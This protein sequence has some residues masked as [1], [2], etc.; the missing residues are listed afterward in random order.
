MQAA[1]KLEAFESYESYQYR[2]TLEKKNEEMQRKVEKMF[3]E[4][5]A[6]KIARFLKMLMLCAFVFASLAV[7]I[8]NYATLYEKQYAVNGLKSEIEQT[9]MDV[10]E[11]KSTLDST[12]SLDNVER[13]AVTELNMQYP[14]P[15][16][17]IYIKS[18]W[19]YA[20][21]KPI[22]NKYLSKEEKS[23]NE[24]LSGHVYDYILKFAFGEKTNLKAI[25]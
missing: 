20:L 21:D 22:Q 12:V 16:Q 1:R 6:K 3:S 19:H 11:I 2:A 23:K 14:K 7:M 25:K 15:E 5:Q 8:F 13:V 4:K 10:E 17:I 9:K 18:N 24:N